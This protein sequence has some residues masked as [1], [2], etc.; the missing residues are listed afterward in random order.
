MALLTGATLCLA[1]ESLC[2]DKPDPAVARQGDYPCYAPPAVLAVLS[3]EELPALQT[4][5][6]A[7]ESCSDIVRRWANRRFFNAYGPTEATVWA[8]IAQIS[9]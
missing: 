7:G 2:L 9:W 8:T 1:R 4:I 3:T 6:A 5:I